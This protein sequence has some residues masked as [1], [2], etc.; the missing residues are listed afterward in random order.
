MN[1]DS[2]AY[3][4]CNPAIGGTAKGHLVREIDALGGRM[5]KCI[6]ATG[7]QFRV[8]NRG[9]GPAVRA[10]RA[11]ADKLLYRLKMRSALEEQ[12]GLDL[13]QATVESLLTSSDGAKRAPRRVQGVR[14]NIGL[15]FRARTVILTTGT[16]LRGLAHVGL[17]SYP[18]GRG[19]ESPAQG[20]TACLQSLGFRTGRLKTGTCPR[21]DAGTIDF[22]AMDEQPGDDPPSPFSY[23][24]ET[25]RQP[26]V[27]C[28]LTYSNA[29]THEI[30]RGNLDRSPLYRGVIE[31]VGPRYCPSIEDKVVRFPDRDRHQIFVEPEGRNTR[32]TYING[33]STSLPIDVQLELLRTIP[34]LE[35][36]EIMRPGYAI[37]YDFVPPTQLE[38]TLETRLVSGLYHAGQI[39]GTS[40]YE[41]AAAQGLMAGINAALSCRREEGLVL[42]RDRAYIGVLIDD[43]VTKGTEE[44]YRMFTSR[45]EYRLLLR[46]DNADLRLRESGRA[47]GLVGDEEY[48]RY[49]SKVSSIEA[50][51][52]RLE[53]TMINPSRGNNDRLR[54]LG[55]T[56]INKPV[57]L[58]ELLRRPELD[59]ASIRTLSDGHS[60]LQG[61]AADEVEAQVKYEGYIRRQ[62]AQVDGFRKLE[63]LL[64]PEDFDYSRLSGLSN[65]VREKLCEIRPASL[66]QASR[67]SGV[68]PSAISVLMV[69]LKRHRGR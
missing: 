1:L 50:E 51:L 64:I 33:V 4:S 41:E 25:I 22:S 55:T 35:R 27:P 38:L 32:E 58:K 20:L 40:G 56:P 42:G 29:D 65:E 13:K 16:F 68:T 47:L 26:Q 7:I 31:G 59:Y 54:E 12:E 52:K 21:V 53:A 2:V 5:A 36:A 19:S 69:H 9:K 30:I 46:Q 61:E 28:W 3:M 44:P 48:R 24:T 6:D 14:T 49:R 34:G 23:A 66:G 60:P 8:L 57:S 63:E 43:L 62:Q 45:A 10:F 15:D 11:Q 67:V 18:S 17:N 39:N 37:E